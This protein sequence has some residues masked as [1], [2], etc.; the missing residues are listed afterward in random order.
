MYL[1]DNNSE[2]ICSTLKNW[3]QK[4]QKN[5]KQL[6]KKYHAT[7]TPEKTESEEGQVDKEK[8]QT[9]KC[10]FQVLLIVIKYV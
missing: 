8:K 5:C 10:R 9:I 4:Y 7:D 3:I 2:R 1:K 6:E